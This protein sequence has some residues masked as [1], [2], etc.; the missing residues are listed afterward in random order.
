[1]S[2]GT[3]LVPYEYYDDPKARRNAERISTNHTAFVQDIKHYTLVILI[4]IGFS[5]LTLL[6]LMLWSIYFWLC[7]IIAVGAIAY[8]SFLAG[9]LRKQ[10]EDNRLICTHC[11]A[12]VPA[13]MR[14][15]CGYCDHVHN[16]AY[17]EDMYGGNR[18]AFPSFALLLV[19]ERPPFVPAFTRCEYEN[20]KT[21]QPAFWC[22]VCLEPNVYNKEVFERS[23]GACARGDGSAKKGDGDPI[24]AA[25]TA[26]GGDIP[27]REGPSFQAEQFG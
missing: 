23:K 10:R 4:F 17:P 19:G 24:Q 12:N 25:R 14:W 22:P 9:K 6:S 15:F 8:A 18:S 7:L 5:A 3:E 26:Y 1:M 27:E 20:C 21:E 13:Y 11:S 2:V 16:T